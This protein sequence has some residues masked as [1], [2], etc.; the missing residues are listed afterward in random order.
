MKN[1]LKEHIADI[2]LKHLPGQHNQK[3]HGWRYTGGLSSVRRGMRSGISSDFDQTT[4]QAERDEYRARIERSGNKPAGWAGKLERGTRPKPEY[5]VKPAPKPKAPKPTTKYKKARFTNPM[6]FVKE[7]V[8]ISNNRK[9]TKDD[10]LYAIYKK[11]GFDRKPLVVKKDELDKMAGDEL[12]RGVGNVQKARSY[13]RG[14]YF[15]GNGIYGNGT[16]AAKNS[17]RDAHDY[18]DHVLK[19]KFDKNTNFGS[20]SQIYREQRSFLDKL[21]KK[22]SPMRKKIDS[23]TWTER[24]HPKEVEKYRG[25]EILYRAASDVGRFAAM[26]G[27]DAYQTDWSSYVVILNRTATVVQNTFE[28]PDGSWKQ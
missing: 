24:S 1:S 23:Y 13:M 4:T 7:L 14:E 26:K 17:I 12:Y 27:Y 8:E 21:E 16:Y 15:V 28:R 2:V 19:M 10:Y 18:N 5:G 25:L 22:M 9:N 3:R 11:Q 6:S 20:Q